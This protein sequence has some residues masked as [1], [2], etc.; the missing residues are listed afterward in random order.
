MNPSHFPE[1]DN[2]EL[3]VQLDD[4]RAGLR[5]FIAIHNTNLGPAAGAT[6]YCRYASEEAALRDAL[7]LSRAMTY[8]CALAGVRYGGGKGVIMVGPKQKKTTALL[9][10]YARRVNELKGLFYTGEDVGLNHRD[11]STM[12]KETKFVIGRSKQCDPPF[13]TAVGVFC[14]IRAG[15]EAVQGT[16]EVAGKTFAIKGLGKVGS[17][18][19]RQLYKAGGHIIAAE[20]DRERVRSAKKEFP[21]IHIVSPVLIHRQK[22]D[23]YSPC[24]LGNEFTS[25][26]VRELRCKMV[27]GGANNQLASSKE[28]KALHRRDILYVPDYLANSG[29][30]IN[31]LAELDRRSLT[32]EALLRKVCAIGKTTRKILAISAAKH[33]PTSKVADWL[34]EAR[35]LRHKKGKN[36]RIS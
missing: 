29:G 28:G 33:L 5:G 20:I 15:L 13:W 25:R 31:V 14:A 19:C 35:F 34:A 11:V 16:S 9:Q 24:A 3:V 7:R 23:V 10:A 22:V 18:L 2:H 21:R 27:C 36:A 6:R 12:A 1:F 4:P 17:A 26:T 8:K 32:R 30:L